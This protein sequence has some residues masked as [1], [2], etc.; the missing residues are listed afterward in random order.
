MN[1][2]HLLEN[3]NKLDDVCRFFSLLEVEFLDDK[4]NSSKTKSVAKTLDRAL[5]NL[6][7]KVR[8]N[9]DSQHSLNNGGE[10]TKDVY[11]ALGAIKNLPIKNRQ[12]L[13]NDLESL[14]LFTQKYEALTSFDLRDFQPEEVDQ[15]KEKILL[16]TAERFR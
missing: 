1:K 4:E 9:L 10:I 2:L 5:I 11:S 7:F 15:L 16:I 12:S 6:A 14:F 8:K 3:L 13:D